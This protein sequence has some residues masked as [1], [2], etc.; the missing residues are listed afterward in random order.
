MND[1]RP[2]KIG[3]DCSYG[4]LWINK[5]VLAENEEEAIGKY[6]SLILEGTCVE[7]VGMSA[8]FP[9]LAD[10]DKIKHK[11]Q[12]IEGVFDWPYE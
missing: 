7:A 2:Y 8:W 9:E 3:L 4:P 10:F 1:K 6:N 11:I 12:N 5:Y